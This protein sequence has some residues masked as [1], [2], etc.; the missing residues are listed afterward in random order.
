MTDEEMKILS[1]K[2]YREWMDAENEKDSPR[3]WVCGSMATVRG[4]IRAVYEQEQ[5]DGEKLLEILDKDILDF[6]KSLTLAPLR[7]KE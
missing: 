4:L 3:K 2:H 5:S 1:Y 6:K 7:G